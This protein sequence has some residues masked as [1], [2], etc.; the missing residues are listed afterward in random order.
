[1]NDFLTRLAQRSMGA[2]PL[3]APRLPSLFAPGEESPASNVADTSAVTDAA[4]NSTLASPPLQSRPAERADRASGEPRASLYPPRRPPVPDAAMAPA[5]AA[6]IDDAPPRV[7]STLIPLVETAPAN[8]QAT[9]PLLTHGTPRAAAS[10]E[11]SMAP[12]KQ[13]TPAAA[14]QQ[15]LPLLPQRRAESAASFPALA[16]SAVGADTG[17]PPAPTVH[18]TIGRVE[19]RA[20][21][22]TPSAAPRPRTASKPTLSLGDYLKRGRGAS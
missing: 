13:D 3:I 7:E 1:M 22:A 9:P 20:N 8:T 21:I 15:W 14:P 11:L 12:R 6:R 17:T 19:V 16:D 10:L 5:P 4:R 18:I 2:A